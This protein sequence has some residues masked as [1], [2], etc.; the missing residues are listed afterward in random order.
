MSAFKT[1]KQKPTS[2]KKQYSEKL[3]EQRFTQTIK[4]LGGMSIKL[5]GAVQIGLPDRLVLYHCRAYFA[6]FKTTGKRPTKVQS[7]II[8]TLKAHGFITYIIDDLNSL[9]QAIYEI[10]TA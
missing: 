6:E 7:H 3:L 5:H 10:T 2:S 1:Q 9:N 8:E 4:E